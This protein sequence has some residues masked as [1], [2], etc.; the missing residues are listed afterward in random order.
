MG[1]TER[2][3]DWNTAQ[4]SSGWIVFGGV[5]YDVW[6]GAQNSAGLLLRGMFG[7]FSGTDKHPPTGKSGAREHEVLIAPMLLGTYTYN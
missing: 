6:T 2:Q 3:G 4:G 1:E 5:G 7:R